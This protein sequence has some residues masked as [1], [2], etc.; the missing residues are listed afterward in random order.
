MTEAEKQRE[1]F[2]AVSSFHSQ[3]TLSAEAWRLFE[4][5]SRKAKE[6][7]AT[8]LSVANLEVVNRTRCHPEK[9]QAI[10]SELH[11]SGLVVVEEV[12]NH[13]HLPHER[14]TRYILANQEQNA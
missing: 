13:R 9:L 2:L 14:R 12:H 8:E 6:K 1:E 5:I 11:R 7:D 10:Q 3:M 4:F